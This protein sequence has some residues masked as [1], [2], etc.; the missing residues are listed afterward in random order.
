MNDAE[1][2][3]GNL[4]SAGRVAGLSAAPP[5]VGSI[6][7]FVEPANG[8]TCAELV[9]TMPADGAASKGE[10][11]L[12][13]KQ[14]APTRVRLDWWKRGKGRTRL[15]FFRRRVDFEKRRS[16]SVRWTRYQEIN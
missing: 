6:L 7:Y 2:V 8:M 4:V 12:D 13:F 15:G 5:C 3:G 14:L 1:Q 16:T 11:T 10:R 9:V